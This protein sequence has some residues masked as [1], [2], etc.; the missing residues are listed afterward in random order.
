MLKRSFLKE[1]LEVYGPMA[2]CFK[3]TKV[4]EITHPLRHKLYSTKNRLL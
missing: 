4:F 2:V 1:T 3:K